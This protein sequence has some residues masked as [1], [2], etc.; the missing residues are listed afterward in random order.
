LFR[1]G[2]RAEVR[3]T[4]ALR[5]WRRHHAFLEAAMPPQTERQKQG[6][7]DDA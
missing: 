3:R 1:D 5:L 7:C 4:H 6:R 2:L